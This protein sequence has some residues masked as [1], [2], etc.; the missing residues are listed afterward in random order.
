MFTNQFKLEIYRISKSLKT[1]MN[2]VL[3]P[4]YEKAGLTK[5]QL[6]I[7]AAIKRKKILTVGKLA[8]EFRL[9]QGNVSSL[10]KK[11]EQQGLLIR[12][13]S[14]GDER[15]VTLSATPLADEKMET[16]NVCVKK[17]LH[18]IERDVAEPG[19][20][21]VIM[22]GFRELERLISELAAHK[23]L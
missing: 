19:Q 17:L 3:K 11:L 9:N 16:V 1:A 5:S 2:V 23:V 14:K 22:L 15:V 21:E 7:L 6:V 4:I 12:T 20:L 13:R 8:Q 10:C 18:I